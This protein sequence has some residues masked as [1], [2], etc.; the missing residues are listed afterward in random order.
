MI[1]D[2]ALLLVL[3]P[4][5]WSLAFLAT[6]NVF[7][8]LIIVGR[9]ASVMHHNAYALCSGHVRFEGILRYCLSDVG[10]KGADDDRRRYSRKED[11]ERVLPYTLVHF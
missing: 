11:T 3:L 2:Y 1:G 7:C 6:W 9:E 8:F 10:V 5:S 4:T